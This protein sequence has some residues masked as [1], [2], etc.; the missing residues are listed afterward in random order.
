MRGDFS[1]LS[2]LDRA[3]RPPGAAGWLLVAP[4][5]LWLGAFV[6]A[7]ALILLVYSFARRGTLGGVVLDRTLASYA[8]VLDPIYL[9][10]VVRSLVYAAVTTLICIVVAY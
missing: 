2:R 6:L 7:P 1:G 5:L 4:L 9:R 3:G 8:R 10:I